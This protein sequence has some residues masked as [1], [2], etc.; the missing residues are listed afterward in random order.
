MPPAID[1]TTPAGNLRKQ[2]NDIDYSKV[3]S[4]T[5]LEASVLTEYQNLN[6]TLIKINQQLKSLTT[7]NPILDNEQESKEQQPSESVIL[8]ENLRKLET[9]ISFIYTFFKGAVYTLYA[10]EGE[11]EEEE[12]IIESIT[13]D[14]DGEE[15][16]EGEEIKEHRAK[17]RPEI[18]ENELSSISN[19]ND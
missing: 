15:E 9:K 13:Y 2:S 1:T 17:E 8:I 12:E 7:T 16:H 14:N 6:N 5:E 18:S 19:Y 4:L 10:N 3:S 11:G